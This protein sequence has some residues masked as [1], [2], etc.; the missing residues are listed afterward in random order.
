MYR[1]E[2]HDVVAY[3]ARIDELQINAETDA[4]KA[5]FRTAFGRYFFGSTGY[6]LGD[7]KYTLEPLRKA[8]L[9]TLDVS[10]VPG[11]ECARDPARAPR[12]PAGPLRNRAGARDR[13][14]VPQSRAP[15]AAVVARRLPRLAREPASNAP[16]AEQQAANDAGQVESEHEAFRR[17]HD[18]YVAGGRAQRRPPD[19]VA[20][21]TLAA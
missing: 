20:D 5:L 7:A 9:H 6:F 15:R 14:A 2:K 12:Q 13:G 8:G 18:E 21:P 17:A 4:E 1:P 10:D 11:I 16:A 19:C 3:D